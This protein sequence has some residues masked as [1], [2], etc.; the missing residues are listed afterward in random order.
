MKQ[1]DCTCT[2]AISPD[3]VDAGA[4]ITLSVQLEYPG[5]AGLRTPQVSILDED[6]TE[7]VRAELSRSEDGDA[8]ESN[9]IVLMA[10]RSVGEHVYRA[11]VTLADKDGT[12][13]ELASAEAR[14][15]VQPHASELTIWDVPSTVAAGERLK[16]KVGVRCSAGCCLAG[17]ALS[18]VDSEGARVGTAN[19][20]HDV[21]PGTDTLYVAE[22]AAEA[23]PTA[24]SHRWDVRIA[25]LD[26]ELPHAAGS[27]AMAVRVVDPPDCEITIEAFD[28]EKQAP[29]KGARV[30]MHPYRVL[31]DE[32]GA[33]KVK[34]TKGQY[35]I[36]VSASKY[37]PVSTTVD[38]AADMTTRTELDADHP[39]E[40]PDEVP[41]GL[42]DETA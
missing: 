21:W 10:P 25:A 19:L 13:H 32:N 22:V 12:P 18:I 14:F 20:G 40:S 41:V 24:G 7:L 31:T 39:W 42:T 28:R 4:A 23:P 2:V 30:V 27:L 37:L 3:E 6:G 11:I 1:G 33:A 17:Q 34:V 5:E 29:I 36:L 16:F 9:D 26:A 35:D 38:V 15:I 8:Y